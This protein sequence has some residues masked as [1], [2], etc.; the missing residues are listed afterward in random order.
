MRKFLWAAAMLIG[1]H[2][3]HA[4]DMPDYG[5]LRGALTG[6]PDR[7]VNWQGFYVG[8]QAGYG[9][10][11]MNFKNATTSTVERLLVNTAIENEMAVSTWPVLGKKSVHGSGYGGFVGYNSQ[12]DDVVVGIEANYMHGAFGG[13]DSGSMARQF[14]T[15]NNVLNVVNYDAKA[16]IDVKDMGSA[17]L[18]AGYVWNSFLPYLFGAVSMGQGD[19]VRSATISGTQNGVPFVP[20]SRIDSQNGH[21]LYGYGGGLGVDMMLVGGLFLR[22][23]WEYLKFAAP[24][25]TSVS[26]VRAGVGYKF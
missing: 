20:L 11:D 23:E 1:A 26:T 9:V 10:S 2:G 7:I 14:T 13:S 12:W 5:P 3:A 8:G 17:R 19:I 21:F 16:S 4:A 6:G 25:D 18:R 22:A 15:S 24:I